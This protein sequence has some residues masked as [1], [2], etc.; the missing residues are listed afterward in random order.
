MTDTT[1]ITTTA[2]TSLLTTM[3][4]K[5]G[6]DPSK[7]KHTLK[8]TVFKPVKQKD[9]TY[10]PVTDEQLMALLIVADQ[11][12]LNP[13]VKEIYAFPSKDGGIIPVVG[14]DGWARIMNDHPQYDGVDFEC[15]EKIETRT[16]AK[17]CNE[18][19]EC[20]IYRKD[21]D[22]PTRVREYLDECYKT[23]KLNNSPWQTHTKRFLR[24]KALIQA[25]RYA[26]GFTGIYDPDEA[27]RIV[28][29]QA[30]N[31]GADNAKNI[32]P[33]M[34]TADQLIANREPIVR[35]AA[36]PKPT[37]IAEETPACN[38]A[39]GEVAP[40][41]SSHAAII[42]KLPDGS[43]PPSV[44]CNS[45]KEAAKAM[46]KAIEVRY[47]KGNQE[48]IDWIMKNNEAILVRIQHEAPEE[49]KTI[50]DLREVPEDGG[51]L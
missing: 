10:I 22:K 26:F 27:H 11:Y 19:I 6:V 51:L 14:V 4:Q 3:A 37:P 49:Y 41:G 39:T 47:Q 35:K 28:D 33:P 46:V 12:N 9:N 5:W 29:A 43:K 24:H 13:F 44:P 18:W 1:E 45:V 36:K 2:G 7:L 34:S 8:N 25:A 15:S 20:I 32:T 17:P 21:R 40:K 38:P 31:V 23:S 16:G 42:V 48:E 30:V 50:T